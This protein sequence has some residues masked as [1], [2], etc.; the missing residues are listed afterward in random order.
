MK[1]IQFILFICLIS[2][3]KIGFSIDDKT[4]VSG[5]IVDAS[6]QALAYASIV[7]LNPTD[8]SVIT[9]VASDDEGKFS[10]KVDQ[11]E[12]LL[13]VSFLSY[14]EYYIEKGEFEIMGESF[15]LPTYV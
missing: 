9:G 13:K 7:F 2:I 12:Y 10:I 11:R 6:S 15:I 14:L 3:S 5:Q 1:S 8:S 4:T